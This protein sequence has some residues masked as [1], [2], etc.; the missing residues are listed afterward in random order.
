MPETPKVVVPYLP[1]KTFISVLESFSKFLPDHVHPSMWPTYSGGVK[2]QVLATLKFL[3]LIQ[4]DGAPTPLLRKIASSEDKAWPPLIREALKESYVSLMACDLTKATPGSF[5]AEVRKFGQDGD[6]HRK[7]ASFFLQA[8]K[9]AGVPLSPLL[10]RK[11]GLSSTRT[12]KPKAA[13]KTPAVKTKTGNDGNGNVNEGQSMEP[14][15]VKKVI[16]LDNDA[17]LLLVLDKNFGDLP[18]I[19]RKFVNKLIDAMEGF[20]DS[21]LSKFPGDGQA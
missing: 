9:Y 10:T 7:A 12:K 1:W 15:G 14:T 19:Q 17:V 2:G 5:D 13:K 11:G 16:Q 8:A 4:E 3:K 18:S 20:V 21:G 6:T